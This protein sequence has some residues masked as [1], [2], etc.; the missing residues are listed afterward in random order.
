M[1]DDLSI[2]DILAKVLEKPEKE[3]LNLPTSFVQFLLRDMFLA[4]AYNNVGD[5]ARERVHLEA[6]ARQLKRVCD[7]LGYTLI[8]KGEPH[9][10]E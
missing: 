3:R 7:K 1:S 6:M 4:E 5:S 8:K 2:G 10:G 9:S